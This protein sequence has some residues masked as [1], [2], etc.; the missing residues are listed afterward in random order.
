MSYT[1]TYRPIIHIDVSFRV[2]YSPTV[3][4]R[5]ALKSDKHGVSRRHEI[6]LLHGPAKGIAEGLN[7]AR[8][9]RPRSIV[10]G[11]GLSAVACP[12]HYWGF[13]AVDPETVNNRVLIESAVVLYY[14]YKGNGRLLRAGAQFIS[15]ST[16]LGKYSLTTCPGKPCIR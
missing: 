4:P 11:E 15:D 5:F 12:R 7:D 2:E 1:A 13:N 14:V 16:Y 6:V 10:Q 8:V 3:A 9:V